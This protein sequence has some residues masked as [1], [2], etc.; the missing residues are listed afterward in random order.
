VLQCV[1]VRYIIH[2]ARIQCIFVAQHETCSVFNN[3]KSSLIRRAL[4]QNKVCKDK[5][6][7]TKI[8]PPDRGSCLS[9]PPYIKC[10]LFSTL[11]KPTCRILKF[12]HTNMSTKDTY[13]FDLTHSNFRLTF[14]SFVLIIQNLV[15]RNSTRF[16]TL[17]HPTIHCNILQHTQHNARH[18]NTLQDAT[19]HYKKLQHTTRRC[20]TLQD[21]ETHC[22]TLQHTIQS[23]HSIQFQKMPEPGNGGGGERGRE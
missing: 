10:V 18:C 20:N 13:T 1:T 14:F 7:Y 5:A 12:T 15:L 23:L 11:Q 22:K 3:S 9:S 17:Q 4:L 21:A 19:T 8:S 16:D 6:W 2:G